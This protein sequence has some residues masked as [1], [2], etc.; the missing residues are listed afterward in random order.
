M[1]NIQSALLLWREDDHA[2]YGEGISRPVPKARTK[3]YT[4]II[5]KSGSMPM[6]MTMRAESK[7]AAITYAQNRWP[8]ATV[9]AMQ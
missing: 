8:S 1:S 5:Y 9:E 4:L 7:A 6:T 2:R 3:L